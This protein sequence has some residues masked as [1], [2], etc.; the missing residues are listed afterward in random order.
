LRR[1]LGDVLR[2]ERE[3]FAHP[4]S[5]ADWIGE[6]RVRRTIGIVADASGL[7]L[8]EQCPLDPQ[9]A[10]AVVGFMVYR[11]EPLHVEIVNFAV[12][13]QYRRRGVGRAMAKMLRLKLSQQ[14]RREILVPVS[15]HNLDGQLFWRALGYRAVDIW[16][17]WFDDG[18]PEPADA[19]VFRLGL[20]E[21]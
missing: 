4:W 20:G 3:S 5:A 18:P 9:S 19:Y 21:R 2:I 7:W 10:Q 6:L 14:G 13:P 17:A 12:A 11:A 16:P 1:D 8:G 15:E